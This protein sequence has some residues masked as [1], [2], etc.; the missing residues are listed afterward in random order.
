MQDR[1][2]LL[3]RALLAQ[4]VAVTPAVFAQDSIPA[5]GG[6]FIE[7]AWMPGTEARVSTTQRTVR[8]G[9]GTDTDMTVTG[10]HRMVVSE[11]ADGLL[12]SQVDPEIVSV[13]SDPPLEDGNPML[14]MYQ[15]LG[16]IELAYIVSEDGELLDLLGADQAAQAFRTL[17]APVL[18]S[19][20]AIPE[21]QGMVQLLEGVLSEEALFNA[22]AEHW[23]AMVWTWAWE[24]FE[25]G[26]AYEFETDEPSPLLPDISVPMRHELGYLDWVPCGRSGENPACVRLTL[27]SRPA[28]DNLEELMTELFSRM[29]AAFGDATIG[30]DEFEQENLVEVVIE[31]STLLPHYMLKSKTIR[32]V[33]R[34]EGEPQAFSRL[35]STEYVF[36]Y[37]TR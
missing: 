27:R 26:A 24:E 6:V 15:T 31:P 12:V 8:T 25:E 21:A 19:A 30:F 11:H 34:A 29:G 5:V 20:N 18:D 36:E 33:I 1:R 3:L 32:G 37:P 14:A 4:S 35:D 22:A 13:E 7:F 28:T 9:Q 2:A 23:G 10:R 16:G 17:M